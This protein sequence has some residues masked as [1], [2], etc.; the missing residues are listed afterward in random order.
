MTANLRGTCAQ[1]TLDI[2]ADLRKFEGADFTGATFGAAYGRL[3]AHVAN[4]AHAVG[5]LDI[6]AAVDT[7]IEQHCENRPHIYADGSTS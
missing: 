2:E 3:A 5:K 1:I 6:D 4:L 7:A